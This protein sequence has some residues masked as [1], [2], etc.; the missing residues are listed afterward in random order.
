MKADIMGREKTPNDSE[1]PLIIVKQTGSTS[2]DI[3]ALLKSKVINDA[4]IENFHGYAEL[5]FAQTNGHG[6]FDRSWDSSYGGV[7]QSTLVFMEKM[8]GINFSQ[9]IIC[10]ALSLFKTVASFLEG[11]HEV[12]IKWPND[13]TVD[14]R[15]VC[16]I[17]LK[18][19]PGNG[20]TPVIIGTGINIFNKIDEAAMRESAILKPANLQQFS[21]RELGEKDIMAVSEIYRKTFHDHINR[22]SSGEFGELFI[23]YNQNLLYLGREIEVYGQMETG[24]STARGEFAGI[25]PEGFLIVRESGENRVIASGEV[26][27][28]FLN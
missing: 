11:R 24:I 22:A 19:I 6:R 10:V 13:I 7:Y 23:E 28:S 18:S 5:A 2:D 26:K 16:G 27:V 4:D 15:K 8:P 25:T 20:R 17:L 12:K 21:D 1:Y 14:G 3:E 9:L